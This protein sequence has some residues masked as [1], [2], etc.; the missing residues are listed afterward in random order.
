[1]LVKHLKSGRKGRI[2]RMNGPWIQ[3]RVLGSETPTA[4]RVSELEQLEGF[5]PGQTPFNSNSPPSGPPST[6]PGGIG[7]RGRTRADFSAPSHAAGPGGSEG[8]EE[9]LAEGTPRG[10]SVRTFSQ[11]AAEAAAG[12]PLTPG[13]GL[14]SSPPLSPASSSLLPDPLPD[15][16]N[17]PSALLGTS[18][19]LGLTFGAGGLDLGPDGGADEGSL[20]GGLDGGLD[21]ASLESRFGS[22]SSLAGLELALDDPSPP[23]SLEATTSA[24]PMA[25]PMA[26]P[27]AETDAEVRAREGAWGSEWAPPPPQERPPLE[28]P[29]PSEPSSAKASSGGLGPGGVSAGASAGDPPGEQEGVGLAEQE[30]AEQLGASGG[31]AGG[32]AGGLQGGQ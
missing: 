25:G 8:E 11:A 13:S 17:S 14:P 9:E 19:G 16:M 10:L 12:R 32:A 3:I 26:G 18:P 23:T 29:P 2:H 6:S 24:E 7:T 28:N 15:T 31:A 5:L 30:E 20:D 4:C 27:M 1:M 21:G 22:S